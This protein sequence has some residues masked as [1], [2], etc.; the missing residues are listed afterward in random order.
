[1]TYEHQGRIPVYV[2]R[3]LA[4]ER[5]VDMVVILAHDH[6]TNTRHV[7]SYGKTKADCEQAAKSARWAKAALGFEGVDVEEPCAHDWHQCPR[8]GGNA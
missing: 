4:E 1:M 5:D 2:A 6:A 8:C 7:V 3:E